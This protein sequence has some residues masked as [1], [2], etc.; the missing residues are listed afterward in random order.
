MSY[1]EDVW[2]EQKRILLVTKTIH[3]E[4]Y[5]DF[6][7]PSLV[8]LKRFKNIFKVI[9]MVTFVGGCF[10]R[11]LFLLIMPIV[12]LVSLLVIVPIICVNL[13]GSFEW[14]CK[15]WKRFVYDGSKGE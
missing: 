1:F 2:S 9:P 3:K 14:M 13:Q 12:V 5:K 11:A 15:F 8:N 4:A 6:L 10:M 7:R